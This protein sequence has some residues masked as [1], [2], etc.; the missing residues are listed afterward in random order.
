MVKKLEHLSCSQSAHP[1]IHNRNRIGRCQKAIHVEQNGRLFSFL[2]RTG[3]P[4]QV[5]DLNINLASE[6]SVQKLD[7]VLRQALNTGLHNDFLELDLA[8]SDQRCDLLPELAQMLVAIKDN[9]TFVSQLLHQ[10]AV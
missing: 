4:L 5:C 8:L 6:G 2:V 10:D 1:S 9:V 3:I 7:I